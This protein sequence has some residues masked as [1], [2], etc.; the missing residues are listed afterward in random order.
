MET[1][2]EIIRRLCKERK[3]N[4]SKME[5][6]LGFGNGYLNPKK[7]KDIKSDRLFL[8]LDYLGI[9]LEE[10]YNLGSKK[11]QQIETSLAQIKKADPEVYESL[12]EK[13]KTDIEEDDDNLAL[14]EMLR[15]RPDVKILFDASKDAPTSAILEAAALIMKYKEASGNK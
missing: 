12:T 10:F 7:A 6:D 3:I 11:T 9:S 1:N 5:K 2:V 4:I 8:I 14:R 15:T 13:W